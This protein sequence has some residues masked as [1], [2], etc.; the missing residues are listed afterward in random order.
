MCCL[1][2]KSCEK[3]QYAI[4]CEKAVVVS[5][6]LSRTFFAMEL[7]EHGER[8]EEVEVSYMDIGELQSQGINAAVSELIV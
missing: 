3:W 7:Q 1:T 4:I 2:M 6:P 5:R 8:N